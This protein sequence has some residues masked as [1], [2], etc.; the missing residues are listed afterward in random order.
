MC[1]L[2]RARQWVC[3]AQSSVWQRRRSRMGRLLCRP[4]RR[5][6]P[7]RCSLPGKMS[8]LGQ[9]PQ[10]QWQ[11]KGRSLRMRRW[12]HSRLHRYSLLRRGQGCS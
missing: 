12:R 11:A 4:Q 7:Q 5:R 9:G 10:R 8:G 3:A 6:R 1:L 2:L